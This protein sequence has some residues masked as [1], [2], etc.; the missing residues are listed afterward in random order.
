MER[1]IGREAVAK[2]KVS[3]FVPKVVER[4]TQKKRHLG[5][6]YNVKELADK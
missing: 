1:S 2:T 6:H 4:K 5:Y 3:V